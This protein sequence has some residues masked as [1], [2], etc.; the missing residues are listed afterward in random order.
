MVWP[1]NFLQSI[2]TPIK[3]K[4]NETACEDHETINFFTHA[5]KVMVRIH[6]LAN[7]VHAETEAVDMLEDDQF[8]LEWA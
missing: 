8:G 5:L 4:P 3:K 7:R 6:A 2:I 1:E